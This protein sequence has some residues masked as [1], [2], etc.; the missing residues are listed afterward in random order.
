MPLKHLLEN[1]LPASLNDIAMARHDRVK[2]ERVDPRRARVERWPVARAQPV[3][4]K[5]LLAECVTLGVGHRREPARQH[6]R[7]RRVVRLGELLVGGKVG[8][9]VGHEQRLAWLVAK[10]QLLVRV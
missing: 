6:A 10:D 2:V 4:Q 9:V 5:T 3:P 1:P 7:R 8:E